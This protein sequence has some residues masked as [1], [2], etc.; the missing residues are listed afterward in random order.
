[1][2]FIRKFM[3]TWFDRQVAFPVGKELAQ[4]NFGIREL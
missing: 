2:L 3:A 1:M 4:S